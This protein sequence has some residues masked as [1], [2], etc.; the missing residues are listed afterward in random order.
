MK[1][2][3]ERAR[4]TDAPV[5]STDPRLTCRRYGLHVCISPEKETFVSASR[6]SRKGGKSFCPCPPFFPQ[7]GGAGGLMGADG[8]VLGL[9]RSQVWSLLTGPWSLGACG[10][11]RLGEGSEEGMALFSLFAVHCGL[12]Q[13]LLHGASPQGRGGGAGRG[14]RAHA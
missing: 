9:I 11:P 2:R 8:T 4:S 14:H 10:L 5:K 7:G 12:T 13:G 3:P 1:S 6:L